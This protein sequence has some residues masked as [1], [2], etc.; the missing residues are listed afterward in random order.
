M[1]KF[2][3][4]NI[5]KSLP[6]SSP[7]G[8][9][10]NMRCFLCGDSV[11]NPNKKRL[12]IL[13][14]YNQP[15]EPVTYNCFNCGESGLLTPSMLREMGIDNPDF[16]ASIRALNRNASSDDGKKV[17][18]YKNNKEIQTKFPPLI[19]KPQVIDKIKYLYQRIGYKIPMEDF[20]SNK[21]VFSLKDFLYV[22]NIPPINDQVN[23][24]DN[25][26]IGFLSTNNEYI[27]FRD[28][29]ERHKMRYVKYNIYGVF[30][31]TN[32]YYSVR[33]QL[34]LL[35]ED[36]IEICVAEGTFDIMGIRYNVLNN[37]MR[38]K[39]LLASCTAT[40]E[41]VLKRYIAKGLVGSNI[42]ISCYIDNGS[43]LDYKELRKIMKPYIITDKNFTVY[44]NTLSKDFGVPK[45]HICRDIYQV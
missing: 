26:Y 35:T 14:D 24:L 4:Y 45:S 8:M 44:Y 40:F 22:N 29:T 13:V 10:V 27:I 25:D 43:I 7:S 1:N 42:K 11:K 15:N 9:W 31:N 3:M 38:N 28:I 19:N 16:E 12:G 36:D 21:L 23:I 34:D 5:L 39:V 30:D 41:N 17:S 37:D 32:S 2:E 20:E 6:N 18:K 33:N